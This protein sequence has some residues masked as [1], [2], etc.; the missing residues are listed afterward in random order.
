MWRRDKKQRACDEQQREGVTERAGLRHSS[1]KDCL[2][3]AAPAMN[4]VWLLL[5]ILD[6]CTC[7]ANSCR[8]AESAHTICS[9]NA[10][11]ARRTLDQTAGLCCSRLVCCAR[12]GICHRKH[13]CLEGS[14]CKPAQC[15]SVIRQD[16]ACRHASAD[17]QT[18][19]SRQQQTSL[20]HSRFAEALIWIILT[21]DV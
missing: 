14:T 2:D 8:L 7:C 20:F 17:Q 16:K 1:Y 15:L 19:I 13:S 6:R 21:C 4:Q 5:Y 9:Q 12:S 11:A 18:C 3:I 10:T